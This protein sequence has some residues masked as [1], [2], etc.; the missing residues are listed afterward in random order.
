V[1]NKKNY[2]SY[3]QKMPTRAKKG[4][5]A[6]KRT[7]IEQVE[8]VSVEPIYPMP[9]APEGVTKPLPEAT[10]S[11]VQSDPS[12]PRPSIRKF[13]ATLDTYV[14]VILGAIFFYQIGFLDS[15]FKRSVWWSPGIVFLAVAMSS[16]AQKVRFNWW[17]IIFVSLIIYVEV[18]LVSEAGFM[19]GLMKELFKKEN[20]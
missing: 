16:W 11:P 6:A 19:F 3:S 1:V 13:Y 4:S 8:E 15:E 12:I 7:K 2:N 9:P 17:V 10:P 14:K 18:I 5:G 20:R